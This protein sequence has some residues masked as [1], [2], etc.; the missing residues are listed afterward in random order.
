MLIY[1]SCLQRGLTEIYRNKYFY[2]KPKNL[3]FIVENDHFHEDQIRK[4]FS[5]DHSHEFV[6][7]KSSTA[8]LNQLH[9]HPIAVLV[10]H[11][12][13]SIN[14]HERD[15]VKIL[16]KIKELEHH[17]EVVF[18]S[19]EENSEVARDMISHGAFDYITVNDNSLLRLEK[20]LSNI[21]KLIR[22]KKSSASYRL[23]V[24][25]SLFIYTIFIVLM[26]YLYYTG[27]LHEQAG[28][29]IEP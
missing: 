7:F 8:C 12:L 18:F 2:M 21:E 10:D 14:K 25:I 9:R 27:H 3:V 22:H 17:T 29:L 28:E 20:A 19:T 11:E 6:Y 26:F 24:I 16:E 1:V 15:A 5:N 13:K 4:N 23:W